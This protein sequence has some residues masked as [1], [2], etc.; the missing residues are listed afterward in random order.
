MKVGIAIDDWKL[1]IFGRH[2]SQS[3]YVFKNAG[4][5]CAST[6]L[7]QVETENAEALAGVINAANTEAAM[8]G[9][10]Q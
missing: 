7:L 5:L 10:P 8:T 3:G 4:E 1:P 2:L 6:L 9:A